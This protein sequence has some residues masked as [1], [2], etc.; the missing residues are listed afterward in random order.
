MVIKRHLV[1][2]L[3]SM[4]ISSLSN[5]IEP[6]WEKWDTANSVAKEGYWLVIRQPDEGF[7]F[8]KQGYEGYPDKMEII[9]KNDDI[10][11]LISPF[12][13]GIEGDITYHVDDGKIR[14]IPSSQILSLSKDIVPELKKGNYLYIKFK[15]IGREVLQQSF[16]LSGFAQA[17]AWLDKSAC[18]QKVADQYY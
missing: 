17:H 2:I 14:K 18:K 15:P 6:R 12:F 13:R 8:A 10:P 11:L 5:A 1:F 4:A 7:C 3:F 9:I 16:N